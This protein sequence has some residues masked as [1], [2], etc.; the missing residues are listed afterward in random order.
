MPLQSAPKVE[1]QPG[2][3]DFAPMVMEHVVWDREYPA[4]LICLKSKVSLLRVVMYLNYKELYSNISYLLILL[5]TPITKTL[6]G[7]CY[8]VVWCNRQVPQ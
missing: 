2:S 3:G 8:K 1:G 6:L 7:I 5:V 4:S